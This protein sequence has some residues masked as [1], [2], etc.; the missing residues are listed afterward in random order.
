MS[1]VHVFCEGQTEETF[2]REVLRPHFDR[3]GIWLNAIILRTGPQGKGGVTSFGKLHWQA[4]KKCREDRG[5]QVT[6]LI[7]FYGLPTDFP[8][9]GATGD[10]FAR[11]DAVEAAMRDSVNEAN[12]MPNLLVH[13]FE[14]LLFSRPEVFGAWFDDED[15]VPALTQ[16]REGFQSPEHINDG[17][18]TAPSKR[19]LGVCENY[20][21]VI[22]GS[23]ISLDIG[24]DSI[25][26]QC[27]RFDG[28]IRK[29]EHLAEF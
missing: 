7:D 11:A 28:W 13:E 21:K 19:I 5:A 16:V 15:L 24:L 20:D 29:L 2:L 17:L 9:L 1:R 8:G 18:Q 4:S 27:P 22:H 10:S 3:Y 25:R 23:L 26:Q 14:S 12:F 6:T